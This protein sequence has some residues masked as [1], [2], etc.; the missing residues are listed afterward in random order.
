MGAPTIITPSIN[1]IIRNNILKTSNSTEEEEALKTIMNEK[2]NLEQMVVELNQFENEKQ[3]DCELKMVFDGPSELDLFSVFD[4]AKN[5]V[6]QVL[7]DSYQRFTL[8][9]EYTEIV[10]PKIL[11]M[12]HKRKSHSFKKIVMTGAKKL[13]KECLIKR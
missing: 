2:E 8:T 1:R 9:K 13:E 7:K 6:L 10:E 11:K 5:E 4:H 3:A 12:H